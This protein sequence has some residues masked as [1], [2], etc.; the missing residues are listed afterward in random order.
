MGPEEILVA[1]VV[2]TAVV[3]IVRDSVGQRRRL[4]NR[5][6]LTAIVRERTAVPP[7]TIDVPATM[8]AAI[9]V[10]DR[11]LAGTDQ[12]Q[13]QYE[14]E[15]EDGEEYRDGAWGAV[16]AAIDLE[17]FRPRLA[18]GCE[19]RYFR[20][21]WGDDYAFL[22]TPDRSAHYQLDVWEARLVE[23]LDGTRTLGEVVVERLEESGD[24]DV[25]AVGSLIESLRR[26]G[27]FDPAPIDLPEV[28]RDR[29]DPAST[30]RKRLAGFAKDLKVSWAGADRWVR[31]LY[32]A[33]VHVLF[34]APIVGVLAVLA[35]AGFASFLLVA[36]EGKFQLSVGRASSQ[37]LILILLGFI[38][39]A[40]HE[41]GHAATLVHFGRKVRGAG[42]LLYYG[43]PA[44]FIDTSDGLMLDRRGRILQAAAGPFAELALAGISSMLL[45]FMSPGPAANFLYKFAV[46]NYYV[47]FLNLIPLL[48]LDGYW[49][50]ADAIE[51][52]E[53]RPRSIAF[54]RREMWQKLARHERFTLQEIGFGVY[55]IVGTLFTIL[56]SILGLVLW[57]QV[58][59]GIAVELWNSGL[60]T[61]I[62]LLALVLF[63]AGPAIRGLITLLRAMGR[64]VRATWRRVEFRHQTSWRVEAAEKIDALPM[65]DDLPVDLLNDLAGRVQLR[66]LPRGDT[67]FRQGDRADAFFVIRR[68]RAAIEDHDPDTGDTRTLRLLG[69]G[70]AFGEAGVLGATVRQATV[71]ALEDLELFRLDKSAFDRLLAD[72]I[73]APTFAPTMQA[74]AELRA[75][76]M[77]QRMS[78]GD[79]GQL[80]E[81][82]AFVT[83]TPGNVLVREGDVGDAFY[84]IA[85]GRVEVIRGT[86][87]VAELT[88][89]EHF[90]EIALLEDVPRT[91]SVVATAPL[92][93]F[94]LD[95]EGF[96]AVIANA[97]RT[98]GIR[99]ASDRTREH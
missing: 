18:D 21:R 63:F 53:L 73:E 38:L 47:I 83:A 10:R 40:A 42:F 93:A 77:F 85:S 48:E 19:I 11:I 36:V 90:G 61:R 71:R 78:S 37:T 39:T 57:E 7:G 16:D 1:I 34:R 59:G 86:E 92:R 79:L 5:L 65:F 32:R 94:R 9:G 35:V 89:G 28:L 52:P 13:N 27:V 67:V 99:R 23:T 95:R 45:L 74:Y 41:L 12:D 6:D 14:E 17:T 70:D 43:S 20:L 49:I 25:G 22:A 51:E 91:A 15:E 72:Q 26:A 24:L 82:G 58:F 44:F 87:R 2:I 54:I 33:G 56:T 55:G 4:G 75:L 8:A 3:V 64:R 31:A 84:V 46:L 66:T 88:T 76:P 60:A 81:H 50:L 69:P 96:E 29:L 62:L 30:G 80:L 97:F 98:G 68:G